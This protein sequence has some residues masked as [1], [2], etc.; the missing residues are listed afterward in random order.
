M[1]G[2]TIRFPLPDIPASDTTPESILL[3]AMADLREGKI[4]PTGLLILTIEEHP[5]DGTF[6]RHFWMSGP[7]FG[8]FS[9]LIGWLEVFKAYFLS[10]M[11]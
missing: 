1:I 11:G 9:R 5:E 3:D 8:T 2:T 4:K 6:D 7:S 10:S